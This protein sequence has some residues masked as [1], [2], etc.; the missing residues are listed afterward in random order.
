LRAVLPADAVMAAPDEVSDYG[1]D[2]YSWHGGPPPDVVLLPRSTA[3]VAAA[4]RVCAAHGAPMIPRG[5]GTSLEGHT[6]APFRG[7]CFDLSRMDEVVAVRPGDLDATVQAGVV[8]GNLN[9]ALAPHGLFFAMDP[10]PGATIGGMA[11]TGCSGTNA[12]RY[13]TMKANVLSLTVVLADGSVVKTASRARKSSAGYDL[14]SLFI[15]SE[16]TLGI[17]TEATV[18]LSNV[19][20][21]TAV[22]VAAFPTIRAASSAVTESMTAGVS[23][24]AVELLDAKMV[25][26][27]NTQSGFDYPRVPH[28]LFKFTGSPAKVADDA[29]AVAAIAARHGGTA[30][31]WTRDKAGQARLWEARKVA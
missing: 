7:V 25:H 4:V 26:A 16:G 19:P 28:L 13:G 30:F 12:V 14:T 10:G 1:T 6:T 31:Q 29:A 15:G 27:V 20:A 8:W 24:G 2:A 23:L 17:V 22:A 5:A 9:E 3:E 21:Q 11:G 18:R